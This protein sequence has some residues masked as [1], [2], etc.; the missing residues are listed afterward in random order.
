LK[1]TTET[2]AAE[3]KTMMNLLQNWVLELEEKTSKVEKNYFD[4]TETM[5][6]R[7]EEIYQDFR[8]SLLDFK[9]NYKMK[10]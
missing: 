4:A 6:E 5:K 2:S 9:H 1:T 8:I 10:Q 7:E 3:N